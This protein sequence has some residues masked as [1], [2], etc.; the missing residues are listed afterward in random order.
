V[1]H[2]KNVVLMR[3]LTDTMYN[4]ASWPHVSH[5]TGNDLIVEHIEKNWCPTV[6]SADFL[7]G[8]PLRFAADT[9]PHV[10]LVMAEDEYRTAETLTEFA[11]RHLGKDFRTSFV[12]ASA[13]DRDH[14][15]GIEVLEDA[16]LAVFSIRR[17]L[18]AP[19]QMAVVRRYF[20]AGKP[21]V[22]IRTSSHAFA[23]RDG[24][25]PDGKVEWRE[26]DAEVLGGNYTGH[27][28]NSGADGPRT[29][30]RV[31]EGARGHPVMSGVP[32][33]EL[34]VRSWLYKTSPLKETAVVLMTGRVEGKDGP[35][36]VAWTNTY[37][38]HG[39]KDGGRVF[40]TSLG[41]PE[42]F[43]LPVFRRLLLNGVY[44]TGGLEVPDPRK[45]KVE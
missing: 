2:G 34:A 22:A 27:H 37:G 12:Y 23:S 30:V 43:A 6:T 44:W 7:G 39:R 5:F 32:P 25:V 28:G 35:E 41:H 31:A 8:K 24:K 15:P 9:R 19:E 10:V 21:L 36:P 20:A 13:T 45:L 18:L 3:D 33:E 1:L 17:R 16:D 14:L 4:P 40:Y 11:R 26:F 38:G 29:W 42:D